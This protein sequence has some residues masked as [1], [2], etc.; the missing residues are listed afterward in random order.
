MG[1]HVGPIMSM[2][3]S[4]DMFICVSRDKKIATV[5]HGNGMGLNYNLHPDHW[6]NKNI[7]F[8]D[9]FVSESSLIPPRLSISHGN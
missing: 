9:Q 2:I 7:L 3:Q 1:L 8:L 4:K 5:Q 6:S